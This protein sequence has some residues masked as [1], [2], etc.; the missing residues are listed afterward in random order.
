MLTSPGEGIMQLLQIAQWIRYIAPPLSYLLGYRWGCAQTASM[1]ALV[2]S[3]SF[4]LPSFEMVKRAS[5][6]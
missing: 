4:L 1:L 6:P 2:L 5:T 3:C